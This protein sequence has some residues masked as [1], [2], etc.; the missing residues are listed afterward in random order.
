VAGDR[1]GAN[2]ALQIAV[3]SGW[4]LYNADPNDPILGSL[5]GDPRYDRPMA[6]VKAD[7]ARMRERVEREGW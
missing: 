4:R 5:Q 3:Q 7:I 6:E 1:E 2:R